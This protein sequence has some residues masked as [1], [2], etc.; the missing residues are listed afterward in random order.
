MDARRKLN[1]LKFAGFV[2]PRMLSSEVGWAKGIAG[3]YVL[4]VRE[5]QLLV[6]LFVMQAAF[7][8]LGPGDRKSKSSVKSAHTG[9]IS[10][11]G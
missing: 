4:D 5:H 11:G 9:K 8:D 1:P 6:L 7:H 2:L 3:E 10:K